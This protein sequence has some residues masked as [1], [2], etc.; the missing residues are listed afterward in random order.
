MNQATL[1]QIR[2]IDLF[3]DSVNRLFVYLRGLSRFVTRKIQNRKL[4]LMLPPWAQ[5]AGGFVWNI[6]KTANIW[7]RRRQRKIFNSLIL[8]LE[9]AAVSKILNRK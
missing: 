5:P 9:A 8:P 3:A 1:H 4:S 6:K 2:K 7:R